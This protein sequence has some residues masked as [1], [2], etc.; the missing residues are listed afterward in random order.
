MNEQATLFLTELEVALKARARLGQPVGYLELAGILAMAGPQRIHRLTQAL[1]VLARR[2]HAAGRPL[3]ATLAVG[4][5][6]IPGRGFF[7]LLE[8]HGGYTLHLQVDDADAWWK[9]A[10]EAGAEPLMPVTDMFWGDRYG[11]F[12]DPF[13]VRW[14]VGT[15][16][17]KS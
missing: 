15:T 6:G 7:Q 13:G 14:S 2:D 8:S 12:R 5:S 17:R 1:E 16:P 9:R 11:Q 10:V 4:R 3:L